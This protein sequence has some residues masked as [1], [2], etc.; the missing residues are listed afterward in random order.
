MAKNFEI[1]N[2]KTIYK[3]AREI[4]KTLRN[5]RLEKGI[6]QIEIARKTG[7]SKQMVSKIESVDGNPT[8][9]TLVKYCNCI[10]IDLAELL[11]MTRY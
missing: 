10:G 4:S 9:Q 1:I 7:L 11:E 8:L 3:Q 5:I 6:S 2:K